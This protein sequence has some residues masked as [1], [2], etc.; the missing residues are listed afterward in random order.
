MISQVAIYPPVWT[1]IVKDLWGGSVSLVLRGKPINY[2][3]NLASMDEC[4]AVSELDSLANRYFVE[5][6]LYPRPAFTGRVESSCLFLRAITRK[7]YAILVPSGVDGTGD[8]VDL[9]PGQAYYLA[10]ADCWAYVARNRRTGE[11]IAVHTGR[12]NLVD[13]KLVDEGVRSRTH[14][15]IVDATM[16]SF[17]WYAHLAQLPFNSA[18]IDVHITCGIAA[19]H[20]SHTDPA[21]SA[22]NAKL[23]EYLS[24]RFGIGVFVD[25]PLEGKIDMPEL[26][27]RQFASH[28]VKSDHV[29][30]DTIDTYGDTDMFGRHLWWSNRRGETGR[31]LV[32]VVRR[33]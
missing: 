22:F 31:N 14:E 7:D 15:S 23:V 8:A 18:D 30:Q 25:D 5:E 11:V 9:A 6:V 32:F 27:R 2:R 17:A 24:N 33:W 29:T 12:N 3:L 19:E 1:E 13:R 4:P 20:F 21:Y 28:G 10:S 16:A 26:I